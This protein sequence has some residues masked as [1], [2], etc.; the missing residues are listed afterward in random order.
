MITG[1]QLQ[2][3]MG[4]LEMEEALAVILNKWF[5]KVCDLKAIEVTMEDMPNDLA[6]EGLND[7]FHYGWVGLW[8]DKNY[9]P[10]AALIQR[11]EHLM[12]IGKVDR[13]HQ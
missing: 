11:V 5:E 8:D 2:G 7:L 13:F 12:T 6:K 3:T 9:F 1:E 4:R 10:R